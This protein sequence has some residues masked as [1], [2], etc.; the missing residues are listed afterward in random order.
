MNKLKKD[1]Q[2]VVIA[3]KDKGKRGSIKSVLANNKLIVTGVNVVKKHTKANPQMGV[4]GGIVERE[5]PIDASNVA[6]FNPQTNKADRVGFS[7]VD[8]KKLRIYKSN[9]SVI[10]A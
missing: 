5:A 9:G 8:G 2:V 3:G 6:I 10:G 1:D 4:P 7:V